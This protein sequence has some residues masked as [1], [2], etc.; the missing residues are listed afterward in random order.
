MAKDSIYIETSPLIDYIKGDK[1]VAEDRQRNNWYLKQFLTAASNG[2]IQLIT[3]MLTIAECRRAFSDKPATDENKR[4]VR[5]I[6]TSG[7]VF[8][9][10]EVTRNI[11]T[12]ARDL[13]WDDGLTS[14]G[15]ADAIHVA[16]AL[17]TDCKEL[18]ST[19]ARNILKNSS[20]I[21]ALGLRVISPAGTS[22][23]PPE[24]RQGKLSEAV[25]SSNM[26]PS[27]VIKPDNEETPLAAGE[28]Q[29][30]PPQT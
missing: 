26:Q 16:T 29:E 27:R 20:K 11:A 14:L 13:D 18:F 23:L 5:S 8:T 6:L 21:E 10:A 24:Y 19:D 12:R 4:L 28:A 30:D 22:L 25:A 15:G 1:S 7:R 3:S 2:E 17:L 9:L